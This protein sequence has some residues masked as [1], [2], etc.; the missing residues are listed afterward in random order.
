MQFNKYITKKSELAH[1]GNAVYKKRKKLGLSQEQL[2]EIAGDVSAS[3]IS[4]IERQVTPKLSRRKVVSLAKALQS[5]TRSL[6]GRPPRK[7][8]VKNEGVL[9][10][11][12]EECDVLSFEDDAD[13]FKFTNRIDQL[14]DDLR[15][16]H[17]VVALLFGLALV[18]F[19]AFIIAL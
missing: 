9:D 8:V 4:Q 2:S 6:I 19:V 17:L 15:A 11:H 14:E 1:I 12:S 16:S 13:T 7:P 18:L 3:Y 10:L 5:E